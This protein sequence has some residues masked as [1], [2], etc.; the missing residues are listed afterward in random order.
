[1]AKYR[2]SSCEQVV[3]RDSDKQWIKSWCDNT[4]RPVDLLRV[5]KKEEEE[6][7]GD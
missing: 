4:D 2:C 6:S 7:G 5:K 3:E 1:M